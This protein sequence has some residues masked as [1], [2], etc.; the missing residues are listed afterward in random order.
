MSEPLAR[1]A[2]YASS[3][4]S[5][6]DVQ[7][8][9][10]KLLESVDPFEFHK[11]IPTF[12]WNSIVTTN[13]DR[14]IEK[15]YE[16]KHD[17][18]Q[19]PL[20]IVGN[21]DMRQ[22]EET[23]NAVP[24][25]KIH[26]CITRAADTAVPMILANEQYAK[27]TNGRERLATSFRER[28]MDHAIIFCGYKLGDPHISQI[29]YSLEAV[30]KDRPHYFA[31]DPAFDQYDSIYW[32][33]YN[34]TTISATFEEF[35]VSLDKAIP[36]S[37]RRLGSLL[38][39]AAG[40]L[41]KWINVGAVL[42]NGL[43]ALLA[44]KLLH[45]S[46]G[47]PMGVPNPMGFYRGDST[48]WAPIKS[49]LDFRRSVSYT[50]ISELALDLEGG[51]A[52]ILIHGHAGSGK[53]VT[54][55]RI[56]WELCAEPHNALV[57]FAEHSINGLTQHISELYAATRT[58]IFILIDDLLHDSA[59]L[60]DCFSYCQRSSLPVTF[61]G[62]ARTNEWN[63]EQHYLGILP[64]EEYSISDLSEREAVDL[65]KLLETHDCL[66]ELENIPALEER[67]KVLISQ[68]E[69]QLLVALHQ[70]TLGVN[71]FHDLL[72]D[73][74]RNI[75]PHEAQLLYLDICSLHRLRIPVR[76]GLIS[77]MSGVSFHKFQERFLGPLDRVVSVYS[78]PLS[79]DFAYR[80]RH[81]EIARIV[82]EEVLQDTEDRANQIARIVASLN[83]DFSSD[84]EAASQLIRGRTLA[85]E[86][87]NRSLVER[88][89]DAAEQSGV[90]RSFVLQQ[91]A[92]FEIKHPDGSL[93]RAQR[94]IDEAIVLSA[95]ANGSLHHTKA[96][97]LREWSRAEGVDRGQ[98]DRYREEALE[99]IRKHGLLK[100]SKYG[101]TTYC[102]LLLDQV[103]DKLSCEDDALS[104]LSGEVA[105]RKMAELE[106]YLI[107]AAQRYPEDSFVATLR[108]Q[109]FNALDKN[110]RALATL[111]A[112]FQRVPANETVALRLSRQLLETETEEGHIEALEVLRK[113]SA[114]NPGSKNVSF[115]LARR[116]MATDEFQHRAEIGRLLS[117]SSTKG[118][119][120]FEAQF[121]CARHEFIYG[122]R[123]KAIKMYEEFGKHAVP[124]ID[125]GARRG[126]IRTNDGKPCEYS[127]SVRKLKGDYAFVHCVAINGIVFLHRSQYAQE[128]W[129][130]LHTGDILKF[131]IAFTFRG[132]CCVEA[133]QQDTND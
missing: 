30:F 118:D 32:S 37:R 50:V 75:V 103:K 91:R 23:F 109:L 71:N 3:Q 95:R 117:R 6:L 121:W 4:T 89:F 96:V 58:R 104:A 14:V 36:E 54:I 33:K 45:I 130:H 56:G 68:N 57:L 102:E 28:A 48:S 52:F 93:A 51:P 77:R 12:K 26:G 34:M 108:A 88:I 116:L 59:A 128:N 5:L 79:K 105:V 82:F 69:R 13:Y 67:A 107:E 47:M 43:Q 97:V 19:N 39:G 24:I 41:S 63:T 92:L 46:P 8:F 119:T 110:P 127:G 126:M 16:G 1:V 72:H 98:A 40:V 31:V 86:F 133:R 61:I 76:A 38:T 123:A 2:D 44:S 9:I 64:T 131:N 81:A 74:Y 114:L 62:C 27:F 25:I 101:I 60:R 90:D 10:Q 99:E 49:G 87:S 94:F 122:D 84:D 124:Y 115:E 11:L 85:D 42:S 106:K 113:T 70:A 22:L 112:A 120:H 83:T 129:N 73:E 53:S 21:G 29:L 17:R 35:I 111:R 80:A 55:K 78:D 100:A 65:C 125:A 18:K 66:G 20:I 7:L 15:S 132:P